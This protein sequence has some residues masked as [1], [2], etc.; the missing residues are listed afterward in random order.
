MA[1]PAF[2][3]SA[4]FELDVGVEDWREEVIETVVALA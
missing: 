4:W 1:P 3:S 2:A